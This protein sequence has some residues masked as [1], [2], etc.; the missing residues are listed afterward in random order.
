MG[1]STVLDIGLALY[2]AYDDGLFDDFLDR[3]TVGYTSLN[4][5][6]YPTPYL[7]FFSFSFLNFL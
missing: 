5:H 3:I 4:G 7:Q 2:E 6:D 1:L